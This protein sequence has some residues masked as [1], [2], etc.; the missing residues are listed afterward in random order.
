MKLKYRFV[1]RNVGGKP[2]AV[3]VGRD[4]E[5]F[6]GMVKL[7]A[8]GEM[9]FKMLNEGSVTLEEIIRRV[10]AVYGIEEETARAAVSDFIDYLRGNELLEE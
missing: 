8:T 3:A 6:N 7:N 10:I 1:V 5:K 9:I 2:V 4:N